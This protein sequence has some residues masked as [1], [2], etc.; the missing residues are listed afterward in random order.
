M[1]RGQHPR[2]DSRSALISGLS[3]RPAGASIHDVNT[4]MARSGNAFR[5]VLFFLAATAGA[6]T[7]FVSPALPAPVREAAAAAILSSFPEA[8]VSESP[9][10]AELRIIEGSES[11]GGTEIGAYRY[12]L[13]APFPERSDGL[14]AEEWTALLAGPPGPGSS[15]ALLADEETARGLSR[16]IGERGF[17]AIRIV[18]SEDLLGVCWKTPGALAII[19]FERLEPRWKILS[20]A[21]KHPL[22]AKA[23]MAEYP[24]TLRVVAAGDAS[25][26]DG[27]KAAAGAS[28][29]NFDPERL[30]SVTMTGVTALARVTARRMDQRGIK[31]PG[32]RVAALL[33]AADFTH[34][35]SEV[36]FVPGCEIKTTPDTILLCSRPEYAGLLEYLGVDLVELTGNHLLDFG[37]AAFLG[38]LKAYD[39]RGMRYFGGGGNAA[40]AARPAIVE[41]NGN[42]IA[43][44]GACAGPSPRYA[45]EKR[46]GP[47]LFDQAAMEERIRNARAEGLVPVVCI[48]YYE[49]YR[50]D[51][52]PAQRKAFRALVGAGAAI[53]QGSQAHQPQ[54]FEFY[55]GGFI[56][57]GLGNIFFDQM[58][59][60]G[61]RESLIDTHWF[62]GG[63]HVST[64]VRTALI[65][66]FAQPRLTEGAERKDLLD[67]VFAPSLVDGEPFPPPEKPNA[68]R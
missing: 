50:Y 7:V 29:G 21:G 45:G 38:T 42:R 4:A 8:I 41:H 36:S 55:G 37:E 62:Y 49:E 20:I 15:R 53:V 40:E 39:S 61:T 26:A 68:K 58:W 18:P 54:A 46:A 67:K 10:G 57:Y 22:D 52:T 33:S 17:E 43:F 44:L 63:K 11:F 5:W 9:I 32:L 3:A 64:V 2:G 24:L 60:L 28:I 13:V 35:S 48:Q 14:G 1:F 31:Y 23:G 30:T 6:R 66:D 25:M 51:P 59:S 47:L 34:V 65:E 12:V 27:L 56:H 16:L 19:P